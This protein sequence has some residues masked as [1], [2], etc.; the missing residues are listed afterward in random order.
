VYIV[1]KSLYDSE[2]L[3]DPLMLLVA[4]SIYQTWEH[5]APWCRPTLGFNAWPKRGVL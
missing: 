3:T 2:E 4:V 1:S 5:C